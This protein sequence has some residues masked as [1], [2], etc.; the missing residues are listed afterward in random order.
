M[1][2]SQ[3]CECEE[4]ESGAPAWMATFA[5]LMSLLMC[6]FVL[7]LSFSEMDVLK[8]KQVAGSMKIAFGVQRDI[9]AV[10]VPKG[11]SI[12]A[13]NYSP[14]RP[15]PTP[16]KVINQH[17]IDDFSNTLVTVNA[18]I[19]KEVQELAKVMVSSLREEIESG[20]LD[21]VM[22]RDS[23]R[24]RIRE[25]DSFP[26][27]SAVLRKPFYPVLEKI[28]EVLKEVD[29][30]IIVSGHTDNVPISTRI[31][32]SNWVLSS[33]RAANVVHHL[34]LSN[35]LEPERMEIRAYA[36]TR[37]AAP[38]DTAVNRARNR[39]VEILVN[40][41]DLPDD[42][43]ELQQFIPDDGEQADPQEQGEVQ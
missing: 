6:F 41:N 42:P 29:G 11:T 5:D 28:A 7:I 22:E 13:R 39:R 16:L 4:C 40:Y 25:N 1:S 38:N 27:G 32:P 37:P 20:V 43:Y 34:A 17:T 8:Y 12:I 18:V 3:D 9:E 19:R 21:L 26:S 30:R 15:E 14:G 36:D 10:E 24:V 33:A 2:D 31:F 35:G 23:V